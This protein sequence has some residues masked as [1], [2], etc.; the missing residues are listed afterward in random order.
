MVRPYCPG[1]VIAGLI[2]EWSLFLICISREGSLSQEPALQLKVAFGRLNHC[3][4]PKAGQAHSRLPSL[5]AL[6]CGRVPV[7]FHSP[8]PF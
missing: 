6:L 8:L 1:M 7:V 3:K 5:M 2:Q 4:N